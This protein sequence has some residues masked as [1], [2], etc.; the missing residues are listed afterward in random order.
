M[1][2]SYSSAITSGREIEE[3]KLKGRAEAGK[4]QIE[5]EEFALDE[6]I[7]WDKLAQKAADKFGAWKQGL[8]TLAS[9]LAIASGVGAPL[10]A[11]IAGGGTFAGGM[12][13]KNQ[14]RQEMK[15]SKY[16]RKG[17]NEMLRGMT[18]STIKGAMVSAVMAGVTAKGAAGADPS[19][20][21]TTGKEG[22][23]AEALKTAEVKQ[24]EELN[25]VKGNKF[26]DGKWQDAAGKTIDVP[27]LPGAA[28]ATPGYMGYG[29]ERFKKSPIVGSWKNLQAGFKSYL[30][31]GTQDAMGMGMS[32]LDHYNQSEE[33]RKALRTSP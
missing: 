27:K 19:V 8:G 14:A 13:G 17:T 5:S 26:V 31:P 4:K 21:A 32:L 24:F 11:L 2:S 30:D 22:M 10:A 25:K 7:K 33:E 12:I 20:A 28:D 1:A 23:S 16:M 15:G 9:G 18:D 3:E 6:K 29:T